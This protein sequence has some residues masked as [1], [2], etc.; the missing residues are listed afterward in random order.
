MFKQIIQLAQTPSDALLLDAISHI[1]FGKLVDRIRWAMRFP[2]LETKCV[3]FEYNWTTFHDVNHNGLPSVVSLT[4]D[5]KAIHWELG[6]H[7]ILD[8]LEKM[9][10]NPLVHVYLRRKWKNGVEDRH[11]FQ[12][13]LLMRPYAF[14]PPPSPILPREYTGVS[15]ESADWTPY[16]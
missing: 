7:N 3:L 15:V 14:L 13:V 11:T 16:N 9:F 12:V 4:T 6:R 8:K 2:S 1:D 5:G 10:D